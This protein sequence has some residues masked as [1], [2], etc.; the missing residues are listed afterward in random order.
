[1]DAHGMPVRFSV[2]AGTEADCRHLPELVAELP[3]EFVLADRAY[4]TDACLGA[5]AALGAEAVIPPKRNRVEQRP[6]DGHIY[7]LR[8]LVENAFEKVKRWRG[9]ATRYCKRASSFEAAFQIRCLTLWL[10]IL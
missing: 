9:L 10:H 8:H 6:Y 7:K 5:V 3:A 4:D 2:T 1:M